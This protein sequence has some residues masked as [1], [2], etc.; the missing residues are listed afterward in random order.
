MPNLLLYM[1]I[2][3]RRIYN[4]IIFREIIV[5]Q[6]VHTNFNFEFAKHVLIGLCSEESLFKI[7]VLKSTFSYNS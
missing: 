3:K 6:H 5:F 7:A 1:H 4:I 2:K